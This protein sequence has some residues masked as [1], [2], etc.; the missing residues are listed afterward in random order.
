MRAGFE[1]PL[2]LDKKPYNGAT[3][4]IPKKLG[5]N[6]MLI[7]ALK[8]TAL[9]EKRV[10]ITPD[11][12]KKYKDMGHSVAIEADA[13]KEAQYPNSMFEKAGAEIEKDKQSL[14]KKADIILSVAPLHKEDV[15]FLKQGAIVIGSLKPYQ[16]HE[17]LKS[18]V[19]AKVTSFSLELLPR[20]TRAQSMDVLSS[21]SNLAGYKAVIDAASEF[22]RALPLMMTA[23]GTIPAA[24]VLVLGAGV[25]GLQA[26]ATAKRLG[27]IVS[28]FDVRAAAKEQV[29]SL[30]ATFIQVHIE[31]TGD[32]QGGYAKEM[33]EEYKKAQ[34]DRLAEVLT[35]QDIVIT[36]AQIPGKP[37]PI[38]ITE[39]M[40]KTMKTG[41]V[42]IDLA[43]ENGG[44]CEGAVWGKTVHKHGVTIVGP[45]N[46][47]S[48]IASDASQLYSRNSFHFVKNLFSGENG[49]IPW[50]DAIIMATAL[51][52]NDAIV[53]PQFNTSTQG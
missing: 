23:A 2:S 28:A 44:N 25:A 15:T 4:I 5:Q 30:G 48:R 20:I 29:E 13:G 16:N 27:A 34:A 9:Y 12:V 41:S 19:K 40:L 47:L 17:L 53:H 37:A 51:T 26:I 50:E 1:P 18:F 8:E 10:A 24:R 21:Q 36:T 22:G 52:R 49:S 42:I 45:A 31:E 39:A 35:T 33:S 7:A 38:L 3:L 11:I 14:L 46:I 32:A 43:V 6:R